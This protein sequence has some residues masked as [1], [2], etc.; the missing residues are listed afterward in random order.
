MSYQAVV[1][2]EEYSLGAAHLQVIQSPS[3]SP[4]RTATLPGTAVNG[5]HLPS[6]LCTALLGL[7]HCR[8]FLV[9]PGASSSI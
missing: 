3:A 6:K 1:Q 9:D 8:C 5:Y 7:K 4:A 2:Q